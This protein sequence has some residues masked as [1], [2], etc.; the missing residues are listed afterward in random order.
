M[1]GLEKENKC[2]VLWGSVESPAGAVGAGPAASGLGPALVQEGMTCP[3]GGEEVLEAPA[4]WWKP[5]PWLW[6]FS[7]SVSSLAVFTP[8]V[9]R[10]TFSLLAEPPDHVPNAQLSC[11]LLPFP[12]L[13][14]REGFNPLTQTVQQVALLSSCSV[15]SHPSEL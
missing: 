5:L 3:A 6:T 2:K 7:V 13:V 1:V 10:P 4:G 9:L 12:A 14:E 15:F 11:V 8:L